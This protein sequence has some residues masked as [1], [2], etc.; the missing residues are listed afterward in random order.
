MARRSQDTCWRQEED[1]KEES[2]RSEVRFFLSLIFRKNVW[3]A[4]FGFVYVVNRRDLVRWRIVSSQQCVDRSSEGSR[5][6]EA[7]ERSKIEWILHRYMVRESHSI[8]IT[9]HCVLSWR[10]EKRC[11]PITRERNYLATKVSSSFFER[12]M[13]RNLDRAYSATST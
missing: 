12:M 7:K 11:E 6:E 9:Y 5:D 13:L 10:L 4:H 3:E 2:K 8:L 1:Q